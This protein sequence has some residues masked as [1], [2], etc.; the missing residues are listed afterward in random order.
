VHALLMRVLDS[1]YFEVSTLGDEWS[2]RLPGLGRCWQLEHMGK[3]EGPPI[4]VAPSPGAQPGPKRIPGEGGAGRLPRPKNFPSRAEEITR[5][6]TSQSAS[7]DNQHWGGHHEPCGRSR[8]NACS[9]PGTCYMD[10]RGQQPWSGFAGKHVC[11]ANQRPLRM[12]LVDANDG[13]DTI[14]SPPLASHSQSAP[15][16]PVSTQ[17]TRRRPRIA[18]SV[19]VSPNASRCA[20]K[21]VAEDSGSI[22]ASARAAF[23]S[24]PLPVVGC[25]DVILDK[26][27]PDAE[28]SPMESTFTP[29]PPASPAPEGRPTRRS[30]HCTVQQDEGLRTA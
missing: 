20:G 10:V 30:V 28:V 15:C 25:S 4:K 29:E 5:K 16:S 1:I 3:N 11:D 2:M 13:A 18:G 6:Q 23:L 19:P 17:C 7:I 27:E 21:P 22:S 26:M 8:K 24:L 14:L 12:A 9:R